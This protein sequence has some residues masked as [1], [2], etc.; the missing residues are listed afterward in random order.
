MRAAILA[1]APERMSACVQPLPTVS[2]LSVP[3]RAA[4]AEVEHV[5]GERRLALRGGDRDRDLEAR[6]RRR[7]AA[8]LD[9]FDGALAE[10]ARRHLA[11]EHR[12]E[13]AG[14]AE[15]DV[16]LRGR[17]RLGRG[18]EDVH[19]RLDEE[20]ARV[21]VARVG[22]PDLRVRGQLR[23]AVVLDDADR[24]DPAEVRGRRPSSPFRAA[25]PCRS[26][27]VRA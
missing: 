1:A 19:V 27:I 17:R 14:E 22:R 7:Q 13:A 18:L 6:R 21:D 12:A 10:R 3:E 16:M 9:G 11:G 4:L 25:P 8:Q 2:T 23:Q 24:V 5:G 20:G 26:T 15:L